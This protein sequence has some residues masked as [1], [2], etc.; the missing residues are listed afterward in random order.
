M[1][2][3]NTLII[4]SAVLLAGVMVGCESEKVEDIDPCPGWPCFK[5]GN[6]WIYIVFPISQTQMD[7]GF[8]IL[9]ADSIITMNNQYYLHLNYSG[10][11]KHNGAIRIRCTR[12]S[13]IA[14]LPNG[15]CW[16]NFT[17]EYLIADLSRN[18]GSLWSW[19]CDGSQCDS[20][21]DVTCAKTKF[22]GV[23]K[24]LFDG[25]EYQFYGFLFDYYPFEAPGCQTA[26]SLNKSI[27]F[28][29]IMNGA[30]PI[31]WKLKSTNFKF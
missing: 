17:G 13:L 10:P 14:L 24:Y 8:V 2:I 15:F 21:T 19:N 4:L 29:A 28:Y 25:K 11:D 20:I 18:E 12:N 1:R 6:E 7:T 16:D 27:G 26:Y 23:K 9:K 30:F 5:V 3:R 22:Y 31:V